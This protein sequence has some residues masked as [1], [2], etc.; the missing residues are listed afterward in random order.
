M[1]PG[2]AAAL[3]V[4]LSTSG[5]AAQ[6]NRGPYLDPMLRLLNQPQ[7]RRTIDGQPRL[8]LDV[9]PDRQVLAG[10]VALMRGSAIERPRVGVFVQLRDGRGLDELRAL[11]A[12]VNSV[13]DNIATAELPIDAIDQL[14]G[15]T[16]LGAVEVAQT[17]A[18]TH[19]SSMKAIRLNEVRKLVSGE[20]T[21]ATG[22]NV[23]IADYDTGIDFT[24]E[25]F[26]TATG[27]TR[28]LGLWD[29]TRAAT[30]PPPTGYSYGF[31]CTPQAIQRVIDV[32]ADI[33]QCPEQ[34][35]NGHGTHTAGTAAGDGSAAGTGT[36]FQYAGVAPNADLMIVKGGNG[37]FAESNIIDGLR[38]LEQQSRLLNRP[39]VVNMSLGGQN[40]AHD[41]S[42]LYE[43]AIDDLARPGFI[44]VISSGNE[45]SNNN[46]K[47]RD[48]TPFT[49]AAVLIHGMGATAGG[50]TREFT[51]DVG[52]FTPLTGACNDV[53]GFSLWYKEQDRLRITL[54]RPDGTSSTRDTGEPNNGADQTGGNIFIDNSS[55]GVNPQNGD[56]EAI[57]QANDC[58]SSS[59]VPALGTWTLRITVLNG[60]SGQPYHFWMV[61]NFLGAAPAA[62]ARA[63]FDNRFIVGSPGNA[64][65]AVTVGA[66]ATRMCWPTGTSQA[67]FTQVEELGDLARFSSGGPTRDGRLKPEITAPG[68]AVV[69]VLSRNAVIAT[70]RVTPDGVHLANQGT[71][72]AAPH[73][74]GTIALLLEAKPTLTSADVK[75]VFARSAAR[76]AFTT[77]M[78]STD[79]GAQP[80]DWWGYGKLDVSA[81]LCN[82]GSGTTTF[83]S[84]TPALDTIPQNA[85]L[86]LQ[87]CAS[88]VGG[89]AI[90]YTSSNPTVASVDASGTVRALLPGA[91]FIVA[92]AG[93]IADTTR[94][95]VVPPATVVASGAPAVPASALLGKA[96]T[97]LPLLTLGLRVN[98]FENVTIESL[99]FGVTGTDPTGKLVVLQ[100][101]NR[102]GKIE[103]TDRMLGSAVLGSGGNVVVTTPGFVISQRD[104]VALVVAV[105]LSGG[106]PNNTAFSATFVAQQA[107]TVGVRSGVHD[108]VEPM[109][110]PLVS[111]PAST[112]VLAEGAI[113]SLSENPVKSTSVTFNFK[114]PPSTAAIYTLTG[115]RV[116]NLKAD[117]VEAGRVVWSLQN[118]EGT[119]VA[120]GVYL[121]VFTVAGEV[122][123]EKL[124][125]LTPRD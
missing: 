61:Q 90:T 81:A 40:G 2:F 31:Y 103:A 52:T 77:R 53:V 9:P 98:G 64:R 46:I 114:E 82:L 54:V 11:G 34:D 14:S 56:R 22:K 63:G 115:R 41:G 91:A 76:D 10:R 7:V 94:V 45:G 37:S 57:I 70:N 49:P 36:A 4:L 99:T 19:D 74:T 13:R 95:V 92:T 62:R 120:P 85:T 32:P 59:A 65:S 71:S 123:R 104:S 55:A 67:C 122:I 97:Q 89:A 12:I 69:S 50:G 125:V 79:S 107:K 118:D 20:W 84:V 30:P 29:Q 5:L 48:G 27:A 73:V 75:D 26:R 88:G 6:Q 117:V 93:T 17:I 39:M 33:A 78:Y 3:A 16:G 83:I 113:F 25:D 86:R 8:G 60:S 23:I 116:R 24:H 1:K 96:G 21:G 101:L 105:Q 42:R 109:A 102:N 106:A 44:V 72:M 43:K 51:F 119:R 112:T 18:V 66:F 87:A 111:G 68:I 35:T 108:R 15:A 58:G 80:S 38:W 100:D 47:N 124:F 110:A 28:L 121:L